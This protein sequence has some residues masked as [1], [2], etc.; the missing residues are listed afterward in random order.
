MNGGGNIIMEIDVFA[1]IQ[2]QKIKCKVLTAFEHRET[3]KKY[4]IIFT[5]FYS[6]KY[7]IIPL[8][9]HSNQAIQDAFFLVEEED[10]SFIEQIVNKKACDIQYS[11]DDEVSFEI[12]ISQET[13][14]DIKNDMYELPKDFE[15]S[16]LLPHNIDEVIK[17][18][19]EKIAYLA[20]QEFIS[21]L[22]QDK[23][24]KEN[25]ISKYI[26]N[27]IKNDV[28]IAD[29]PLNIFD[30][31]ISSKKIIIST[32]EMALLKTFEGIIRVFGKNEV[33][34]QD[35]ENALVALAECDNCTN[36]LFE[37]IIKNRSFVE[38]FSPDILR[39]IKNNVVLKL[40]DFFDNE[41]IK[42]AANYYYNKKE[43]DISLK[44]YNELY[45]RISNNKSNTEEIVNT[46]NSIGCCYVGIMQ[47]DKACDKFKEISE[48]DNKY[49]IAYNNWAYTLS[50]E[51][52]FLS[53]KDIRQQKLQ[54][55]LVCINDAIQL[56]AEDVSYISNRAFIEYELGQYNH[57]IKD[58]SRAKEISSKYSDIS[59]ILKLAIDSKIKQSHHSN[60]TFSN[61]CDDLQFIYDNEHDGNRFYFEAL[62]V[63]N[64]INTY[65][66][67]EKVKKITSE[68]VLLEFYVKE[69]MAS[70]TVRDPYQPVY[71][72]TSI[73]SLRR[74]LCDEDENTKYRLPVFS[75][76]HM[77]DPSE[78][79]ELEKVLL[80]NCD[81]YTMIN[82]LFNNAEGSTNSNR[83]RIETEFTFL[84]AF[85]KND[86]S[87]PMWVHYA[88]ACKGCCVKVSPRF[89]ANFD[90]DLSNNE[91]TLITNPFDNEYKLYEILYIQD[92]T[93]A[94]KVTDSVKELYTCII[95][96][97]SAISIMYK[98]AKFETRKVL[99]SAV[100]KIICKLKY[101]FKSADYLYEQEM[102][103]VLRRPI[104]DIKRD[105]IDIKMTSVTTNSAIPKVFIYTNNS[106]QIEEVI[107]GPKVNETNDIVPFL[108]FKLL[109][110]NDFDSS[111]V[112]ITKSEIEYR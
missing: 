95:E 104:E 33:V 16:S 28:S 79:H 47:F 80:Q 58:L 53:E 49:A 87:L 23:D 111:K 62:N 48:I 93:I 64:K 107:L 2:N 55:A 11:F 66:N 68:L 24:E 29:I 83:R 105:D 91:Q 46:L 94:N 108:E 14:N 10:I 36:E 81:E 67:A 97:F 40:P 8:L 77:N 82:D 17:I 63:F 86:D 12:H 65:E 35:V 110:L 34:R 112:L 9:Y 22:G 1:K 70:I 90:N 85:T 30:A 19:D 60:F 39:L 31:L 57:V 18:V 75:A 13:G 52:D 103:V 78:G 27:I 92:G 102:R 99:L 96:K 73:E 32:E 69:L 21:E 42:S 106:I 26:I 109:N 44:L 51:C 74:L 20:S 15:L 45:D 7:T 38:T 98:D 56:S 89:F 43:Y 50:V 72:Y 41:T 37:T 5:P 61:I 88:D 54:E 100:S 71:Y 3:H 59:N 4:I 25:I 76:S 6:E 84:K 101:L